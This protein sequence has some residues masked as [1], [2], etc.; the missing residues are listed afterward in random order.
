MSVSA[1]GIL[2]LDLEDGGGLS[3]RIVVNHVSNYTV[4]RI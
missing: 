2:E 1:V 4:S 3:R